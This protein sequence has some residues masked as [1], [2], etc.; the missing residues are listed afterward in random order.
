LEPTDVPES[1]PIIG[2]ATE[3]STR[4]AEVT[5]ENRNDIPE[6]GQSKY[7]TVKTFVTPLERDQL[8]A[9]AKKKVVSRVVV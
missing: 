7:V 2:D 5:D 6:T 8:R 4:R 9:M 1:A 3:P